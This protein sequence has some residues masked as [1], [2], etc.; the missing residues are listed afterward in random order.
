MKRTRSLTAITAIICCIAVLA[1]QQVHAGS[2]IGWGSNANGL[3]DNI[4]AEDDFTAVAAGNAHSLALTADGTIV[5]WGA[6][7]YNQV[8]DTPAPN[9]FKAIAAGYEF[10]I[11][12]AADGSIVTWGRDNFSQV[13]DA[14]EGA[15]FVAIA[16][17]GEHG[18]A[19]REDGSV[20]HWGRNDDGSPAPQGNNFFAIA[21]GGAHRLAIAG[22]ENTGAVDSWGNVYWGLIPVPSDTDFVTVDAG[23][24]HSIA[25]KSDGTLVAWGAVGSSS[26]SKGQVANTPD[27]AGYIAIAAGYYFNIALKDDGSLV[28]WGQGTSDQTNVPE[29]NDFVAIAAGKEHA[30]AISEPGS[31][32][33]TSP[34][35]AEVFKTG[36]IQTITWETDGNVADVR[37][38]YSTDDGAAWIPVAPANQGNTGSYDWLAPIANSEECLVRVKASA[39]LTGADQSDAT[40]AI[41]T[42]ALAGD[43][44]G[45]C[46]VNIADLAVIAA[47]WMQCEYPFVKEPLFKGDI[48][49]DDS[50]DAKDL[51]IMSSYWLDATCD[52]CNWCG[53]ADINKSGSVDIHDLAEL[54]GTWLL[55]A[56]L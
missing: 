8:S 35:G 39:S 2:I 9:G 49:F 15:D 6:D 25:L 16:A 28:A 47:E 40:L 54:A 1:G 20:V 34:N 52:A 55:K 38:E 18:L 53:G 24:A 29:G 17:G 3:R 26:I 21:C 48:N 27:D 37:I 45:D 10:S 56:E 5:A 42:C 50:V 46:A 4:P 32:T 7:T 44:T 13:T 12:L 11:A 22:E 33:L 30:M 51:M 23:R 41:Y 19:L 31:L 36:T 14:P 43:V